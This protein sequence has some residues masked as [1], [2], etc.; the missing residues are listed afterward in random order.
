MDDESRLEQRL[1]DDASRTAGSSR[2]VDVDAVFAA[3]IATRSPKWRFPSMFSATKFVVASGV[4][5]LFGGILL[6]GTLADLPSRDA[7]PAAQASDPSLRQA[8][9]GPP[10]GFTG[11]LRYAGPLSSSIDAAVAP[12]GSRYRYRVE[13]M[14]DARLDG[15]YVLAVTASTV[16]F[17][18]GYEP[19]WYGSFRIENE[20]G[21]WQEM[22]SLTLQYP[23]ETASTRT[24]ALIGEG[25][26]EG[27]VA[28]AELTYHPVGIEFD[29]QGVVV[30][31]ELP[32]MPSH[33]EATP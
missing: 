9:D 7:A 32:P 1:A 19:L 12:M 21:A 14:S 17:A 27:L 24:S 6:I 23:D 8:D 22:P 13:E 28:I 25:A 31:G 20:D 11:R 3:T 2:P 4:L 5:A 15:D 33:P 16:R 29:L 26:Y 10:G 18:D 30:D